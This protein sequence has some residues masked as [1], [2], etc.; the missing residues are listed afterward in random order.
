MIRILFKRIVHLQLGIREHHL[1]LAIDI[2]HGSCREQFQGPHVT[3][4]DVFEKKLGRPRD[5]RKTPFG[6]VFELYIYIPLFSNTTG[7]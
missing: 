1:E 2:A 3:D 6:R 4:F 7:N 5:F